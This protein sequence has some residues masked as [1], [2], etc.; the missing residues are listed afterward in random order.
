MDERPEN[1]LP[2][3]MPNNIPPEEPEPEWATPEEIIADE[4]AHGGRKK[5]NRNEPPVNMPPQPVQSDSGLP[6]G[7]EPK[8]II[9]SLVV[10]IIAIFLMSYLGLGNWITK[11]VFETN[12][13]NLADTMNTMSNQMKASNDK[14][15]AAIQSLPDIIDDIVDENTKGLTDS[16]KNVQNS[17]SSVDSNVN[18]KINDL[19]SQIPNYSDAIN[20]IQNDIQNLNASVENYKT[21]T[22]EKITVLTDNIEDL[23]SGTDTNT[24]SVNGVLKV[25]VDQFTDA[26]YYSEA[27]NTTMEATFKLILENT[28]DHDI[29]DIFIEISFEADTGNKPKPMYYII[30]G[31]TQ[32]KRVAGGTTYSQ[33]ISSNWG[34]TV[35]AGQKLKMY[36]TVTAYFDP[37]LNLDLESVFPWGIPYNI[38]VTVS[39]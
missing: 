13:N 5:V 34:L 19:K 2:N 38:D 26:M 29:E 36:P 35:K 18:S 27:A 17:I 16:I 31:G 10:A 39:H 1:K 32:W 6:F 15:D 20:T 12:I 4:L 24:Q 28:S 30:A 23:T 8:Q 11:D 14:I 37:D 7:L 33:F 3:G 22:N 21:D 25:T 9:V